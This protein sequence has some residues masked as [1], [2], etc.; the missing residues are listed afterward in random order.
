MLRKSFALLLLL[1]SASAFGQIIKKDTSDLTFTGTKINPYSEEYD[2]TGHF[3]LSGYIDTY[4]ASYTDTAGAGGFQKFP[5]A[6]PR[7][8]Q[9]GLNIA[10]LSVKYQSDRVRGVATLFWGDMP[11]CSWSPNFNF[12]QE[13]NAGFRIAGKLWLDAGFFRTHIGLESIQPRENVTTSFATTTYFEPYYLSG[14]KLTWQQSHKWTFQLNVFNGFNTFVETNNKKAAGVS[15]N[16]AP[17]PKWN[18]TFS[19][20]YTDESPAGTLKKPRSYNNLI[21]TYKSNQWTVGLESNFCWQQH[22]LMADSTKSAFMYSFLAAAKYRITRNWGFYARG[23]LFSDPNEI[24]TG[25]VVNANH[26][27]TG[28]DVLGATIGIE[29]KPIPNAFFRIESRYLQTHTY[30]RVFYYDGQSR[31]HREEVIASLG[32]W[33]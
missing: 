15:V 9:F 31:H 30:E 5:T 24:L 8:N 13:A 20:L 3:T 7:S 4:Y 14:A 10:Q 22:S 19:S 11:Q 17:T 25:P 23:E 32:L 18:I 27:L 33:F 1:C 28:L 6:A 21:A 12:I 26:S 16:Y 29:Y 2:S